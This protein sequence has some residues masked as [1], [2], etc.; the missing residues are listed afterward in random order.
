MGLFGNRNE[1]NI[2]NL[3]IYMRY[4]PLFCSGA[5]C[6]KWIPLLVGADKLKPFLLVFCMLGY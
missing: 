3:N 1:V 4:S 6:V 5:A 2:M